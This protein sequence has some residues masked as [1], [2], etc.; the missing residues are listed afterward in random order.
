M[1]CRVAPGPKTMAVR[2]G[3][4]PEIRRSGQL[5]ES[6]DDVPMSTQAS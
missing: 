2:H 3:K 6:R 5:T 1:L 4:V